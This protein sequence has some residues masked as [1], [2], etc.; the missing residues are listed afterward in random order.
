MI[1]AESREE[2]LVAYRQTRDQIAA[3]ILRRFG[4]PDEEPDATQ[5]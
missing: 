2:K 1:L 4:P 3:R 5:A